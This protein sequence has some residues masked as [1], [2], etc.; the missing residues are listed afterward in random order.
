MRCL[1]LIA[2]A[3]GVA[4]AARTPVIF[5]TDIGTDFD[6]S[7]AIALAL[8]DPELDVKLIVVRFVCECTV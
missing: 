6:D 2:L 1:C 4:L 8:T 7:A 3:T 5:D